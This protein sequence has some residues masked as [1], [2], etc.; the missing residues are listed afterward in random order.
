ML[1]SSLQERPSAKFMPEIPSF[2]A[3]G[4]VIPDS[5]V[6]LLCPYRKLMLHLF[7][8]YGSASIEL[9]LKCFY[10]PVAPA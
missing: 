6:F 5:I 7:T 2:H 1:R 3:T 4:S 9:N 8:S 10:A